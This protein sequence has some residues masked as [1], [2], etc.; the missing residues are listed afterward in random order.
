MRFTEMC[1]AVLVI[2]IDAFQLLLSPIQVLILTNLIDNMQLTLFFLAY[3]VT[4]LRRN[5]FGLLTDLEAN[6]V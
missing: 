6:E 2:V 5:L 4:N 3:I 1:H